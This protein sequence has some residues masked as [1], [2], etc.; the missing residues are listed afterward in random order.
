MSTISKAVGRGDILLHRGSDERIGVLWQESL[1]ENT[2]TGKDLS[3]WQATFQMS[4]DGDVV[5]SLS[6]TC[7]SDGYAWASIPATAFTDREWLSMMNGSWKITA[8]D[9]ST[10]E[11]LGNGYYQLA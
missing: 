9:G 3:D 7:T 5:Y 6:C 4:C 2:Y 8:T 11:I 1:Y 10:T